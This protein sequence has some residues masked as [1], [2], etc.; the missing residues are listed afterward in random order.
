ML[1]NEGDI[2]NY[3]FTLEFSAD[4]T[5]E[6]G[7]GRF[8]EFR[9]TD[10]A[11]LFINGK[12][13]LDLGGMGFNKVQRVDLDRLG[14]VDGEP[15]HLQFFYAQRQRGLGIFRVRTDL[16]LSPSGTVPLVLANFD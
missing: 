2:H 15:A 6:A 14:L 5:Y 8:F 13:V 12:L 1:G 7:L 16:V 10:D 3:H 9:G 4:F 11:Y